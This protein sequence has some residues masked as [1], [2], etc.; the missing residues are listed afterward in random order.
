VAK[1]VTGQQQWI[2]TQKEV[3][4]FAGVIYFITCSIMSYASRR[5]EKQ[6]GVGER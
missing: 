4:A 6:L 5:L 3:Y 1:A 2:G